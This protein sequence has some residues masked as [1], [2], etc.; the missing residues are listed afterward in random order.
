MSFSKLTGGMR[1]LAVVD[2]GSGGLFETGGTNE[3]T[4]CFAPAAPDGQAYPYITFESVSGQNS[5]GFDED[6]HE[7]YVQV[8]VWTD[9]DR[10]PSHGDGIVTRAESV[11]NR[12]APNVSGYTVTPGVLTDPPRVLV[13]DE[14]LHH[15]FTLRYFMESD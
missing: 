10:G 4:G 12:V 13:D 5:A 15:F 7:H 3:V 2:T 9:R 11:L 8:N 14:T 6:Y 1:A